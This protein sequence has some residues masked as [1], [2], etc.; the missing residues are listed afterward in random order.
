MP[1]PTATSTT[2]KRVTFFED[3]AEVTRVAK[4]SVADGRQWVRL[5]GATSLLDDRTVQARSLSDRV[6][7]LSARVV[8]RIREVNDTSNEERQALML[9]IKEITAQKAELT[10]AINRTDRRVSYLHELIVEWCETLAAVPKPGEDSPVAEYAKAWQA[11]TTRDDDYL[12]Q[13]AEFNDAID[14]INAEARRHQQKLSEAGV[15]R[16]LHECFIEVQV[17]AST[18]DDIELEV[19]YRTPCALWRP[20]HMARLDRD[21][22][23]P[24][25]G[26]IEWTTWGVVWH[27]TGEDWK[28]VE[29]AFST[30]R[31]AQ[32]ADAPNVR[33]DPLG[34]RK[35]TAEERKQV[36]V[37]VR[38]ETIKD[39]GERAAAEMPGVDDGGKPLEFTPKGAFSLPGTGQPTRVE[40]GRRTLKASVARVL[41]PERAQTAFLKADANWEGDAPILA[42]P[43][44][45][46]RGNS[47][48]GRS[49][50]KFVAIGQKFETGFGPEDGVRCKRS[51]HEERETAK[52]TGSQ[53]I[54]RKVTLRLSNLGDGPQELLINERVPVSEIEGL[55][56][57]LKEAKDWKLDEDGY[58]TRTITLEPRANATCEFSY[59]IKAKSNVVLPF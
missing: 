10:T 19:K 29:V 16:T 44:R 49:R 57:K 42:G 5:E 1:E 47:L 9:A 21:A 55:E 23:N 38:E 6:Q 45:L 2:A 14:D 35:K 54:E 51:V 13:Q 39:A 15:T 4:V 24:H 12:A 36:V 25:A 26:Q 52:L 58:L 40:V 7:V 18:T 53:T 22:K 32:V 59:E 20:E 11:L 41:M 48:V 43:L 31:P 3:R 46:A 30:A 33:D 50:T 17:D 8:R 34:K 56:V 27:R 37:Q 28:D